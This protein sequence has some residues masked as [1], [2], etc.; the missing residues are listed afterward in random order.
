MGGGELDRGM[1]PEAHS[2]PSVGRGPDGTVVM[3]EKR[4]VTNLV[5]L[6]KSS[7]CWLFVSSLQ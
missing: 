5:M 1:G 2:G 4:L 3:E 6:W 7:Y